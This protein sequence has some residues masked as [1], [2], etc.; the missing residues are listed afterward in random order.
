MRLS[1]VVHFAALAIVF[2]GS[3]VVCKRNASLPEVLMATGSGTVLVVEGLSFAAIMHLIPDSWLY[4]LG[5]GLPMGAGDLGWIV[6]AAGFLWFAIG[7]R[8]KPAAA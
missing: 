8:G 3:V 2:A 7:G 6:F 5:I 1:I 4:Y